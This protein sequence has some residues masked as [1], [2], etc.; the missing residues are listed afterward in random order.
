M[1]VIELPNTIQDGA[2]QGAIQIW[3]GTLSTI[4]DGWALC[5]GLDGRPNL[6]DKFVRGINTS[7]TNPGLTGGEAT[8][9]L[10]V[11]QMASHTHTPTSSG[12]HDH[13]IPLGTSSGSTGV[14]TG[15]GLDGGNQL[16][17]GDESAPIIEGSGFTGS[18]GGG[19]AH[20]NIPPFF[21]VAYIIKTSNN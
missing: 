6:L 20:D 8:V 15:T 5:D 17:L 12:V 11:S 14:Q 3:A 7:L 18:T 21:E 13:T 16:D 9:T 19:G 4:P 2:P 1:P 10:T